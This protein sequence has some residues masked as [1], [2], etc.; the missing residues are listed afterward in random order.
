MVSVALVIVNMNEQL[1][2]R[3]AKPLPCRPDGVVDARGLLL[4]RERHPFVQKIS[5]VIK[6]DTG[7]SYFQLERGAF[8]AFYQGHSAIGAIKW[9]WK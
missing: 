1:P 5:R 2:P 7:L 6:S 4:G 9:P 8:R 3:P